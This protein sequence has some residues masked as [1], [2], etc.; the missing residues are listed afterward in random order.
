MISNEHRRGE[1][2]GIP[3]LLRSTRD[4]IDKSCAVI[5]TGWEIPFRLLGWRELNGIPVSQTPSNSQ[6]RIEDHHA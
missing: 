4:D 2:Y 1:E 5:D 3:T 6:E